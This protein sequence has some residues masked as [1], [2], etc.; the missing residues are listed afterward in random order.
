MLVET[1]MTLYEHKSNHF[2]DYYNPLRMLVRVNNNNFN[3]LT[4]FDED[5]GVNDAF[6][7]V[8]TVVAFAIISKSVLL[9]L[10]TNEIFLGSNV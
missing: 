8:D 2:E 3:V 10:K 6:T 4:L 5:V 1:L 9:V 7:M